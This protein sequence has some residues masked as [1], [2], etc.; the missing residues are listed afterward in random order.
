MDVESIMKIKNNENNGCRKLLT[1]ELFHSSIVLQ[2]WE[3]IWSYN[4]CRNTK[5]EG[6]QCDFLAKNLFLQTILITVFRIK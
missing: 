3:K 2:I 5:S 4:T 6:D 1:L